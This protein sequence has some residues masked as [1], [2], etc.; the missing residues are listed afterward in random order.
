MGLIKKFLGKILNGVTKFI[1]FIFDV[2]I[3][4]F[5]IIV[6][7]VRSIGRGLI[8]LISMGGCLF[9]FLFSPYA[10]ALLFNPVITS[11]ILLLIII[12]ILGTKFVSYLKY[13]KYIITEYLFDRADSL[14]HGR[15]ARYDS[16][17]GYGNRYKRMEAERLRREQEKRQEEQQRQW[18]E[19]FKQWYEYQN[20]QR[21]TGGY[22][23]GGYDYG[24]QYYADP[25]I[26]FKK[27]YEESCDLLGV[28]YDADKYQIKLAY[29][30]K[31]K[32]YHP[33][34]NKSHN[35]KEIFQ[36]INDAN[37]FLSDANIERYKSLHN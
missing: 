18:E 36:K 4:I 29:R 34:L 17:G 6:S 2:I 19:R 22:S 30:R 5:E 32:E 3:N 14:I 27:K 7:L 35:A 13:I 25:S 20:Y 15:K 28:P 12:P 33:D 24:G 21:G 37:E 23:Y 8:G 1:S 9:L 31:A 11:F 16:F 26:E 10:L